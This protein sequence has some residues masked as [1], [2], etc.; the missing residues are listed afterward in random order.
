MKRNAPLGVSTLLCGPG[1]PSASLRALKEIG[2]DCVELLGEPGLCDLADRELVKKVARSLRRAGLRVSSIHS[3]LTPGDLSSPDAE[4]RRLQMTFVA[5]ALEAA[6][7][8]EAPIIV[9]HPSLH[10]HEPVSRQQRYRILG[11]SLAELSAQA[12]RRGARLAVENMLPAHLCDDLHEQARFL[13]KLDL[14]SV[15]ACFDSGHAQVCGQIAEMQVIAPF[16]LSIHLHDN[17]G[18]SDEHLVPFGGDVDW[19]AVCA[20]L[21]RAEGAKA[22]MLEIDSVPNAATLGLEAARR[23]R[24]MVG[25]A[26]RVARLAAPAS[27]GGAPDERREDASDKRA[28]RRTARV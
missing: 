8:V 5:Q 17:H 11:G 3:R 22:L 27:V 23:L 28:R 14:P 19:E 13:R 12:E 15:G 6:D 16:I 7:R 26:R 25:R 24:S 1:V 20:A 2:F 10:F 9:V 21:A 4:Q 18:Q